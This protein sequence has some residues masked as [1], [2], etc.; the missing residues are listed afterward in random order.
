MRLLV[1]QLG[2]GPGEIGL[3]LERPRETGDR[4]FAA[5]EALEQIAEIIMSGDRGRIEPQR[6]FITGDRL[7]GA[8]QS[9]QRGS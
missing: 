4:L 1:Q 5:T 7:V 8:R 2:V 3:Q 6:L 9:C